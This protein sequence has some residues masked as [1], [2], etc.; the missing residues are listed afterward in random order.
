M[1]ISLYLIAIIGMLSC[2]TIEE[3]GLC[4]QQDKTNK[5]C[6]KKVVRQMPI[7]SDTS[8]VRSILGEPIDFGFDY[9]Y[10]IKHDESD[11]IWGAVFHLTEGK[12]D[13]KF[14]GP[15]LE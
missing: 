3:N 6:L 5:K 12:V 8:Y 2:T 10:T 4:Y 13:D 7:G 15:I 14:Y 11:T 9:R 1:K